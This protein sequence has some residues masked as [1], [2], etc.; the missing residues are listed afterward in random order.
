MKKII[1]SFCFILVFTN[2]IF[3]E[4]YKIQ[5]KYYNAN[6]SSVNLAG[7]FNNWS[8]TNN[9]F[10]KTGNNL[11]ICEIEL[12]PGDYE[13]KFVLNGQYWL[14][15]PRN[16]RIT[17]EHENSILT[18]YEYNDI[19]KNFP[20][21][22]KNYRF[23]ILNNNYSNVFIAGEFS[24]WNPNIHFLHYNRNE[25]Y[26]FG[27]Y[28]ILPVSSDIHIISNNEWNAPNL[29]GDPRNFFFYPVKE[30]DNNI[31]VIGN[32]IRYTDDDNFSISA[33]INIHDKS[34]FNKSNFKLVSYLNNIKITHKLNENSGILNISGGGLKPGLNTIAIYGL[35]NNHPI[36]SEFVYIIKPGQIPLE[37]YS[38]ITRRKTYDFRDAILY[39]VIVPKFYDSN[40]DGIGDL[41]GLIQKFP[42]LKDLGINWI[43]TLPIFKSPSLHGYHT[44]DY[45]TIDEKYGTIET[46]KKYIKEAHNN[47][48]KVMLD[49][50]INHTSADHPLFIE[51]FKKP[52]SEF[53][54]W[55]QWKNQN[56]WKGFEG[57]NNSMPALNFNNQ[58]VENYGLNIALYWQSLGVD[59]F[60][61]DVAH[62]VPR[63]FWRKWARQLKRNNPN[64]LLL[65][66][67]NEPYFDM[68]Y[69]FELTKIFDVFNGGNVNM[70][71]GIL[72]TSDGMGKI[73]KRFLSY[74]DQNRLQSILGGNIEKNKLSATA[75]LT[76][77]G[78]PLI[79]YGQEI[80]MEGTM[81]NNTNRQFMDW[82]FG[83]QDLYKHYRKLIHI[84]N[85]YDSLRYGT[86]QKL[87]IRNGNRIFSFVRKYRNELIV[88][89]MNFNNYHQTAEIVLNERRLERKESSSLIDANTRYSFNDNILRIN[90]KPYEGAVILAE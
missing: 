65:P 27:E 74:H 31:S 26:W 22:L 85:K 3:A 23:E 69:D 24:N 58:S 8:K 11:W 84:R 70:L 2:I 20:I 54:D 75:L 39:Q 52:T 41:N 63:T 50:V 83:N 37:K 38:R 21:Q 56:T 29:R 18:F 7:T 19:E 87:R 64:M 10:R 55:F 33:K 68:Y 35:K 51:A 88:V 61:C 43:Y 60:R 17:G 67:F 45:F 78:I 76:A 90:L 53:R 47:G 46:F 48:F 62:S 9:P 66:E 12:A 32:N 77:P 80:G 40:N 36:L 28:H 57:Y 72:R 16:P 4:L 86:A 30:K 44:T 5:F 42:Y 6:V 25:N 49:Y 79:Y 1:L 13:Y 34:L 71:D 59:G 89:V 81:H 82:N 14:N 73:P 15:D